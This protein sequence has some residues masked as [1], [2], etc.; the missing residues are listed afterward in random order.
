M[1]T[2]SHVLVTAFLGDR[3]HRR[4][5]SVRRWAFALGGLA[6]DLPLIV[7]TLGYL[8]W[9]RFAEPLPSGEPLFGAAY[10]AL[11]FGNPFWIVLTSLFHAP[12]MIALYAWYGRRSGRPWLW[13]L[14]MGCALHTAIDVF[15]HRGDGPLLLFPFDWSYRYPAPVSYW[16]PAHGG[17]TFA[18]YENLLDVAIVGYF[19]VLALGWAAG[20]LGALRR[21]G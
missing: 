16:D 8:T 18:L 19:A 11:Y 12:V 4:G 3:L 15:T 13:W 2:Q 6:P 21:A 5:V 9:R 17:A 10:D 1:M 7:L 20:R 14:A